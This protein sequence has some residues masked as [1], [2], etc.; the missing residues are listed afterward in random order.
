MTKR[1]RCQ[2]ILLLT[3][4]LSSMS[5]CRA[6]TLSSDSL[7]DVF[8]LSVGNEW[9]YRY[10][11]NS[12][13]W[14]S[15]NPGTT[16][17]DSGRVRMLVSG[18]DV[19]TDSISWEFQVQRELAHH[20]VFSYLGS[21]EHDTT[22]A[23]RDSSTVILIEKLNGQHQL[24]RNDDPS[25]IRFDVFPFTNKYI[26]TTS[27]WRYRPVDLGDTI[28]IQSWVDHPSDPPFMSRFTFKKGVGLI[29]NSYNSGTIDVSNENEHYLLNATI[30][31][32][33]PSMAS[34]R[35]STVSCH[36]ISEPIQSVDRCTVFLA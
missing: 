35:P 22:Y 6:A 27:I 18:C 33:H 24:Y 15:G 20:I 3:V 14:P 19:S 7:V 32:V 17:T 4:A 29:R 11:T 2:R 25:R 31:G 23:I 21:P 8:P 30:V 13:W 12:L 1:F 34:G 26:D 10:Y 28:R 36:G 9:T 16:T 5:L